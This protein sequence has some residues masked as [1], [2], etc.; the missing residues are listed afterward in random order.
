MK[1]SQLYEKL[2]IMSVFLSSFLSPWPRKRFSWPST[3]KSIK[4]VMSFPW[5]ELDLADL[6]W[7][8][9]W[10]LSLSRLSWNLLV[11]LESNFSVPQNQSRPKALATG[12]RVLIT[13]MYVI[14]QVQPCGLGVWA[15]WT[16]TG[17]LTSWPQGFQHL[18]VPPQASLFSLKQAGIVPLQKMR[19]GFT[20]L[21]LRQMTES[22]EVNECSFT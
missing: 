16:T 7:F 18:Q 4:E 14:K 17:Q 15:E 8:R 11:F 19:L 2:R 20:E 5:K 6:P 10:V 1:Y 22:F 13:V 9:G 12:L 3:A 21:F